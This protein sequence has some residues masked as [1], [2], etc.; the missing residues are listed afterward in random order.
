MSEKQEEKI[1]WSYVSEMEQRL[2]ELEREKLQRVKVF[3]P[4]ELVRRAKD[5]RE[6]S[7]DDLGVIRY[8]LLS[9][10]DLNE[11]IEKYP[12][13]KDRSVQ[14]LF[15]QLFPANKDLAVEDIHKMPFE[16]VVR[17]LTKLQ[18]EGG[19]FQTKVSQSGSTSTQEPKPSD[20]SP[21]NTVTHF[22]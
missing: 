10:D 12:D 14:L 13:N 1:D 22:K 18:K 21:M 8:V 4:K 9:Y 11:I 17:L 20:S 16:V 6:I 2:D 5:I 15:K 3:N 19:F 7:D